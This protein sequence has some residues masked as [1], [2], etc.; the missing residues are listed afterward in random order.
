MIEPWQY[1]WPSCRA[2][3]CGTAD[4]L[5]AENRYDLELAAHDSSRQRHWRE[6]LARGSQGTVGSSCRLGTR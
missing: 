5:L 4:S 1:A 2:Y 3:A 6:F